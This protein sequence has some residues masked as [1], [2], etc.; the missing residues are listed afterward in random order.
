MCTAITVESREQ[1][2]ENSYFEE[3]LP[4]GLCLPSAL[5][6]TARRPPRNFPPRPSGAAPPVGAEPQRRSRAGFPRTPRGAQ[7]GARHGPPRP[8][9]LPGMPS[10]VTVATGAQISAPRR[11]EWGRSCS[12]PVGSATPAAG[13]L[14]CRGK[15]L[16][17]P[18]GF[19]ALGSRLQPSGVPLPGATAS[20]EQRLSPSAFS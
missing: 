16:T 13:S 2:Q 20:R 8:R 15:G 17:Q 9:R 5:N 12:L 19:A 10:T 18:R 4:A 14:A 1:R 11:G 3:A 6:F 7:R